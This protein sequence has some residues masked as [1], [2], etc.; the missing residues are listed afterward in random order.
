MGFKAPTLPRES[1]AFA[2]GNSERADAKEVHEEMK[3]IYD[4]GKQNH[5]LTWM[6]RDAEA[7]ARAPPSITR[8]LVLG[9]NRRLP[10]SREYLE[11]RTDISEVDLQK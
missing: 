6:I 7:A 1:G 11:E 10:R 4:A 3:K 8:G 5:N 9:D 2:K